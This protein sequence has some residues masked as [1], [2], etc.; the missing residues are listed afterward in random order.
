MDKTPR[1]AF[2][3][4]VINQNAKQK[5]SMENRGRKSAFLKP[6]KPAQKF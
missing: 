1:A 3:I 5:G 4:A 2:V 6:S